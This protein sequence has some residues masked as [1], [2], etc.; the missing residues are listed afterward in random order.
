MCWPISTVLMKEATPTNYTW[1]LAKELATCSTQGHLP[2]V[3]SF[4]MGRVG[5]RCCFSIATTRTRGVAQHDVMRARCALVINVRARTYSG[6]SKSST[7]SPRTISF[8]GVQVVT[9]V[10]VAAAVVAVVAVSVMSSLIQC[11][12]F[13]SKI[14]KKQYVGFFYPETLL[15]QSQLLLEDQLLS[16]K[17]SKIFLF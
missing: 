10:A 15:C 9:V 13:F 3:R 16:W 6:G 12:I 11:Y 17:V 14:A 5:I 7:P 4:L 8:A 1:S 2:S